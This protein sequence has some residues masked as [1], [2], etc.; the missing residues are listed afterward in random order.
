MLDLNALHKEWYDWT[1]KSGA[2]PKFLEKRVAWY[3]PPGDGWRYADSIEEVSKETRTLHLDSDGGPGAATD[4][5]HAGRLSPTP[6]SKAG[7]DAYTYDPKGTRAAT[8]QTEGDDDLL[9]DQP[10]PRVLDSA[11]PRP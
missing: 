1:M 9:V 7:T 3:T 10:S 8:W 2:K 11:S 6:V 5:F 4:A